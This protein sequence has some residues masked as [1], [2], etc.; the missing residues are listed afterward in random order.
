MI[1]CKKNLRR[2]YFSIFSIFIIC[3]FLVLGGCTEE[4]WSTQEKAAENTPSFE[5]SAYTYLQG[6]SALGPRPAGTQK[7]TDAADWI[8]GK[9]T[10]FGYE[11]AYE[12]FSFEADGESF[13]SEN[14][15]AE[16]PGTG[17]G[18]IV[19]G[20][21]YDSVETGD[22]ADDN[23]SGVA[24]LLAAAEKFEK[25]DTP[26]TLRFVFFG[27]EEAGFFGSSAHVE[28][29]SEEELESTVCM[30]NFDSLI[31]GDIPYVYGNTGEN[32][33]YRGRALTLAKE[34]G[35]ALVTQ[36]GKNK[37]F[38]AGTTG[39]FSDHAPFKEAGIPYVYFESTNWDL[40]AMDGYTQTDMSLGVDGEIWHT[41]FDDLAYLEET[42]PGRAK[43]RLATFFEVTCALLE[44]DLIKL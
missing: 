8:A 4:R 29:M 20:A 2:V 31:A 21:H 10:G 35:L 12:P 9:L 23:A 33:K 22:G 1:Y 5:D 38:P 40:G 18:M 34:K 17:D 27:A 39:D 16:K 25:T 19:L 43:E 3:S 44:E 15:I 42:F 6:F 7:E 41:E 36:P 30:M 32:G 13:F 37:E 26:Q 28:G 14:I 24:L 11:V